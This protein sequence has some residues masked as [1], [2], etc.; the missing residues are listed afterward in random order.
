MTPDPTP[1]SR[2][3][4]Y[5]TIIQECPLRKEKTWIAIQLVG[6]DDKPIPGVGYRILLA[7]GTT[8]EGFLDSKGNARVDNIDPGTC[9]VTF[10]GLDHD[11]WEGI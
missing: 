10:P 4:D 5:G 3:L 9:V 1:E 2:A 11:A 6:E 7:D 8:Q